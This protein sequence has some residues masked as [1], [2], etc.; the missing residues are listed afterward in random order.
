[1]FLQQFKIHKVK[2]DRIARIKRQVHNY[3][4]IFQNAILD[5]TERIKT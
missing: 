5:K 2:I 1:M 4:Q 3:S